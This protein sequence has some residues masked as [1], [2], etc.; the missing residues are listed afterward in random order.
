[1]TT[2]NA[3]FENKLTLEDERYENGSENFNIHT[4]IRCIP[5]I[6]HASGDDNISLHPST[7]HSTAISQSHHKPMWQW[8][9]FSISDNEDS[10]AVD[11]PSLYNTA[12]PQNPM[13]FAQQ[14]HY[15][16]I[17]TMCDD[18]EVD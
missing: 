10:S 15:K 5:R 1:M 11:I 14:P 6:H 3:A 7:P 12:P 8:L 17:Y 9:S 4:T 16:P 13:G 2:L 18:L